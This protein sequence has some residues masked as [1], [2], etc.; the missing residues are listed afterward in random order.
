[1]KRV[2]FLSLILFVMLASLALAGC[3]SSDTN[4]NPNNVQDGDTSGGSLKG[5]INIIGS[6]SVQ[7]LAQE[8]ADAFEKIES[9]IQIDIQSVGST[10]GVKAAN[11]GTADIGTS[12]RDLKSEEKEWGLTEHVIA[13]DGIAIAVHPSNPVTDLTTEQAAKIFKGEI[14]NWSEVGGENKEIIVVSREAGSGTRGA[15]EEILG[16]ENELSDTALIAEGNGAVKQNIATKEAA[17]GYVS[18]G[19]IDESIKPLK[20]DGVE[21]TVETIKANEYPVARPF[22]MLTKGEL[23][24]EVQAFI[25]FIMSSEGQE[26]VGN[27]YI[28]VK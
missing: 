6:T 2:K 1:M 25:D 14:S 26:I 16:I 22:L 9:G 13:M 20:I 4:D 5:T 23:E 19:Y 24:P 11:D 3:T 27:S 15:F 12:S 8:L 10:A 28:P 7:P 21:A 18:L 17:I